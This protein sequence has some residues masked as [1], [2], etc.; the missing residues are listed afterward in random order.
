MPIKRIKENVVYE[1]RWLRL[2]DDEIEHPD[3]SP[4]TYSWVDRNGGAGGAVV[5]PRLPDG[6]ILLLKMH[7]YVPDRWSWEF[8]G[9]GANS[10]EPHEQAGLRELEEETGLTALSSAVIGQ[11]TSDSGFVKVRHSAVLANV[12]SD[13]EF[14]LELDEQESIAEARWTTEEEAWSMVATGEIFDGVTISVLGLL[15]AVAPPLSPDP[16]PSPGLH[17]LTVRSKLK[18]DSPW[19]RLFEDDIARPDGRNS[20]YVRVETA[21]ATGAIMVIPRTPSGRH[22]LIKI[23]RYPVGKEL[24]E[25]PAGLVEP[26]EDPVDTAIRELAEET[27]LKAIS[28]ELIG[29]QFPVA[30][31]ISDTFFT[32]M[33]EVPELDEAEL[34]LQSEEGIVEAKFVTL[35]GLAEMVKANEIQDGVTLGAIARLLAAEG[36]A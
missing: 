35:D 31:L 14:T 25:F 33:A 20:I 36:R 21:T 17:P 7:R 26:N 34:T 24:W 2:Y 30:G 32:V 4:G 1:N 27:G 22:L 19:W 5:I 9:G 29:T 10:G 28:A 3:G 12:A 6:R 8:P 11:F 18:F 23:F 13:A 16:F 15:K